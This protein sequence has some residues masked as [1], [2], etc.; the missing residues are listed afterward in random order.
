MW[1]QLSVV[2]SVLKTWVEK[3]SGNACVSAVANMR[4]SA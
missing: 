4:H 1:L 3:C 2:R